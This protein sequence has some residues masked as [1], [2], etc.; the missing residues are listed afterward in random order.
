MECGCLSVFS[1]LLVISIEDRGLV[2]YY[3]IEIADREN[4]FGVVLSSQRASQSHQV[5][6][7]D[8]YVFPW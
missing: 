5:E 4:N 6:D 8:E 7:P 1:D 2:V 3:I